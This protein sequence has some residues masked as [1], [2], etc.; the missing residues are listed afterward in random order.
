ML[1]YWSN[2]EQE[3]YSKLDVSDK[4]KIAE[5]VKALGSSVDGA[6]RSDFFSFPI[7]KQLLVLPHC[8]NKELNLIVREG[9]DFYE[10]KEKDF[11]E[12]RFSIGRTLLRS[13]PWIFSRVDKEL[14]ERLIQ[15][16]FVETDCFDL[17][18]AHFCSFYRL[19]HDSFS[20]A[21]RQQ[22]LSK[23]L[24]PNI[25][26]PGDESKMVLQTLSGIPLDETHRSYVEPWIDFDSIDPA[27]EPM[28]LVSHFAS[29]AAGVD[30]CDETEAWFREAIFEGYDD[31]AIL[32]LGGKDSKQPLGWQKRQGVPTFLCLNSSSRD[33]RLITVAGGVYA[34]SNAY[35]QLAM[36]ESTSS[37]SFR[38]SQ[39]KVRNF[40]PLKLQPRRLC[41]DYW[42]DETG[43]SSHIIRIGYES[44]CKELNDLKR[45]L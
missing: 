31:Y 14:V 1:P 10:K 44:L 6:L 3:G 16:F 15:V 12:D 39:Y 33:G 20:D 43:E 18:D 41:G 34:L 40:N 11:R 8:N 21:Q 7:E 32:L 25:T 9:I 36:R 4:K 24:D 29:N 23:V 42:V 2:L 30:V 26:A 22:F 17:C 5:T 45:N 28:R 27:P 37:K 13:A 19:T 38:W 35:T